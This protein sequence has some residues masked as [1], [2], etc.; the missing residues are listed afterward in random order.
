MDCPAWA[1]PIL[2][3]V[4]DQQNQHHDRSLY[5]HSRAV[6]DSFYGDDYM[7][8][9]GWLHDIGKPA[10]FVV[11]P[12]KGGTFYHHAKESARLYAEHYGDKLGHALILHHDCTI[13]PSK[14]LALELKG[15][16]NDFLFKLEALIKSDI[17]AQSGF[18]RI[19]KLEKLSL[20]MSWTK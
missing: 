16:G 14:D 13:N 18:M 2:E 6:A 19:E 1:K 7:Q 17:M 4:P 20:F 12:G 9:I 15:L 5:D 11:R 8:I 10:T 3:S